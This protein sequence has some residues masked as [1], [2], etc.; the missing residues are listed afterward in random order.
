[1]VITFLE[2]KKFQRNLTLV[3]LI[4]ILVTAVIIWRGFLA[5]KKPAIVEV[6]KVSKPKKVEINFEALQNPILKEL[7]PFEEIKPLEGTTTEVGRGNPF[8]PY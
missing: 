1:M 4:V 6:S 5:E 3:F 8:R 7:Q 2:K